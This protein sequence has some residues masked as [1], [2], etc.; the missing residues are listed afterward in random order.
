MTAKMK[1]PPAK[2]GKLASL[3]DLTAD[4]R[5]PRKIGK[6]AMAGLKVSLHEFGDLS[7]LTFNRRT[8]QLVSGHQRKEALA[9]EFGDLPIQK[10]SG[11]RLFVKTPPTKKAPDGE[12]FNIRVVD[13]DKGTQTA[14]NIA[15]N[16]PAISGEFTD[17]LDA[18]LAEVE[19]ESPELYADLRLDE[20]GGDGAGANGEP[21][22]EVEFS[23]ELDEVSNYIVLKVETGTDWAQV[24]SILD[25]KSVNAKRRNGKPWSKG[26][27]RVLKWADAVKAIQANAHG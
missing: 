16:S 21:E 23:Q 25:L 20:L 17:E 24:Q 15:A 19:K 4:P 13:W 9:A 18:M 14:A 27:G 26:V 7:G 2:A 6:E 1:K 3:S 10:D 5:N 22:P 11:G 8:G 12:V